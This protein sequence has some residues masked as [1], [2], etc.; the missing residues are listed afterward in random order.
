[1]SQV[2]TR[3]SISTL[4]AVLVALCAA[5]AIQAQLEEFPRL[6]EPSAH[7]RVTQTLALSEVSVDFSRPNLKGREIFGTLVPWGTVWRTGANASTKLELGEELFIEGNRIPPG[8]YSLLSIPGKDRWTI[9]LNKDTTLWGHYGYDQEK[10]LLRFE[11]PTQRGKDW[12]ETMDIAFTDVSEWAATME[13]RWGEYRIPVRLEVDREA[14]DARIMADIEAKLAAADSIEQPVVRAHVYFLAG[15]YYK[16]SGRDLEKALTLMDQGIEISPVNYFFLY[17]SEV[18]GKLGRY[19]EA[20]AAS[21]R[22]LDLFLEGGNNKEWIYRYEEQ[23]AGWEE[24][25]GEG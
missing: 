1:M 8:M 25:K 18:L 5:S 10:D 3:R 14:V 6:P 22:G 11:V 21:Q 17:K 24:M 15:D 23:I 4:A 12:V 16:E 9:I 19:D 7:C 2:R 20:I 13:I